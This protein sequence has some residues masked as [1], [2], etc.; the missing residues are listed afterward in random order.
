LAE[1][2]ACVRDATKLCIKQKRRKIQKADTG[3]VLASLAKTAQ[4]TTSQPGW[5]ARISTST[6]MKS[7]ARGVMELYLAPKAT[8]LAE[9]LAP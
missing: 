9:E 5:T 6:K 8:D 7:T 3:T 1:E 2:G 4:T